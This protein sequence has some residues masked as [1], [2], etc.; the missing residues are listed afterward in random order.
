MQGLDAHQ[1][2]LCRKAPRIGQEDRLTGKGRRNGLPPK[3]LEVPGN[4]IYVKMSETFAR[5]AVCP[6]T[7]ARQSHFGAFSRR[8]IVYNAV[9]T[10]GQ[11]ADIAIPKDQ[12]T[13]PEQGK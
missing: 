2:S 6:K 4:F 9:N 11:Q 13:V 3:T 12:K 1:F 8:Q 10:G 5:G 7:W